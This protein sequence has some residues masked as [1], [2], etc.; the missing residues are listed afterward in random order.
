[1]RASSPV[2]P[3]VEDD[4]KLRAIHTVIRETS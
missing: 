4:A 2:L 3:S 1:V